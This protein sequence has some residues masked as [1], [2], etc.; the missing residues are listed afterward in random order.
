MSK[1]RNR[2]LQGRLL[3]RRAS[4]AEPKEAAPEATQVTVSDAIRDMA[5]EIVRLEQDKEPLGRRLEFLNKVFLAIL[6]KYHR[7]DKFTVG[8][9]ELDA[10][11]GFCM[12]IIVH[13]NAVLVGAVTEEEAARI[14]QE[15]HKQGGK[16]L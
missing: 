11:E 10:I 8:G 14:A 12:S 16:T 6:V 7:H 5:A 13:P 3:R 4:F 1:D 2:H 15:T 9:A